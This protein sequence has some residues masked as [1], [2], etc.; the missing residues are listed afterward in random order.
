MIP[1]FTVQW[2]LN[3]RHVLPPSSISRPADTQRV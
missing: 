2:W 3:R 1:F